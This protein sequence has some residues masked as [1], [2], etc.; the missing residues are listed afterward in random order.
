MRSL[1]CCARVCSFHHLNLFTDFDIMTLDPTPNKY[2]YISWGL[3][4][5][6]EDGREARRKETTSKT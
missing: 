4:W 3:Q 6:E 2:F 5:G 1:V